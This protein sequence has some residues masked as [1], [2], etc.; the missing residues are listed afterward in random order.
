MA[1]NE[2]NFQYVPLNGKLPGEVMV[3]QTEDAINDLGN[4]VISGA[5][6]DAA[7]A[8][9][10]A[11]TAIDDSAQAVETVNN[12]ETRVQTLE[13][14]YA[15]LGNT[16]FIG[17]HSSGEQDPNYNGGGASGNNAIAIG[18]STSA[19]SE[20]SIAIGS[21]ANAKSVNSIAIGTNA[22]ADSEGSIAIGRYSY[23]ESTSNGANSIAIGDDAS[24]HG[25]NSIAIGNGEI[26]VSGDNSVAIGNGT[27]VSGDYSI[28][29]GVGNR[30]TISSNDSIAIGHADVKA[31]GGIALGYANVLNNADNGIA[32]GGADSL[33][34][35]N[36][37]YAKKENAIAIG[38]GAVADGNNSVAIG[39]DSV[40][41]A[42]NEF[43]IGKPAS[44]NDAEY[45]RKIT[46]VEDGVANSD[47]VTVGQMNTAIGGAYTAGD[48]LTLTDGEFSVKAGTNV[49]VDSSGVNVNGNGTV[50]TSNTGLISGG[51]AYTELRPT[52]DGTWVK[53]AQTTATNLEKLEGGLEYAYA[54]LSRQYDQLKKYVNGN[55]YDYDTDSDSKYTKTVPSGA[56]PYASLD[57]VGGK[58]VVMNQ[59]VDSGTT[60]VNTISGHKYYTLIDG[61]ASIVTSD[62]TAI[63]IVD[64][65]ADMVCD[66]TLMFGSGNEPTTVAEFES[67]FP[68]SYYA[69]NAGSLLSA[70][71][72]SV[73]SK[74]SNDTTLQTYPIPASIQALEGYGWSAGS[75]YNYIDFEK[76]VFV[77]NVGVRTKIDFDERN[78][79]YIT[80]GTNTY[81]P[82]L[83][84][85]NTTTCVVTLPN[86]STKTV[87]YKSIYDSVVAGTGATDF[88]VGSIITTVKGN[89]TYPWA[90]MHH[91]Q[92]QDGR[93]YMHLRV[94]KAV[95]VLQFDSQEAFYYCT[96]ALAAGTY[97]FEVAA[98]YGQLAV[99]NYQFTLTNAVPAGGRLGFSVVPYNASPISKLVQV[100]DSANS[101]VVSQTA[102]ISS[103]SSGTKLGVLAVGGDA[104]VADINSVQRCSFGSNNYA[105]S[106]IRQ[107]LNSNAVA[108]AV[109]KSSNKF[110]MAPSWNASQPGFLTKLPDEF[111]AIVNP[112]TISQDTNTVFEVDYTKSSSYALKDKFWL[113]SRFQIYGTKESAELG[114]IQWDYYK[115]SADIDKIM[116]DNGGT[117]R[118]QWLRSPTVGSA[119]DARLVL[120]G[121]GALGS[122][123]ANTSVAVAPACEISA[124]EIGTETDISSYLADDNLI[125]VEAGGTLTFPN[126]NGSD[127]LIP[128][129]SEETYMIDLQSAIS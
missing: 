122:Y 6:A 95:D 93:Y 79:T 55:Y 120:N 53:T 5:E 62:G 27:Q 105:Q 59:L 116:Y 126:S 3:Q 72:T 40:T 35:E 94:I 91:G 4:R 83:P 48:G 21:T 8:L 54:I 76:Q 87:T 11:N 12:M 85:N 121:T 73:V 47:A 98:A 37:T 7:E 113:P 64:D 70:G 106:N 108:G 20:A 97:Y 101:M 118:L 69:Y 100:Y 103:G 26:E 13:E 84:A 45:K 56:M 80:D 51:T 117:A 129:P 19:E 71:V 109:W 18:K 96:E 39:S 52:K 74:D 58:T 99:G 46:H 124:F 128:V 23:A 42:S 15:G 111:L 86:N 31:S 14:E 112:V 57:K 50:A 24:S 89:Y 125:E 77:K 36:S 78:S 32:I 114:E 67:M 28:S 60:T 68:A 29:I 9:Q 25:D 88:P 43:S 123:F 90:V 61:T 38:K 63:T 127:Y 2:Y 41:S 110:D 34:G 16:H 10:K 81:Y 102:T 44:G 22:S 104:E 49:S 107:Y 82:L 17:V 119:S 115:G 1:T 92:H 75:V 33:N 66:L 65:T 30:A